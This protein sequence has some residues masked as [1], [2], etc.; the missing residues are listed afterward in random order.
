MRWF[1]EEDNE[2][3]RSLIQAE[4]LQAYRNSDDEIVCWELVQIFAIEPFSPQASGEEVI[5]F[6]ASLGDLTDLL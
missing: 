6:F 2:Q 5:G 1:D 4:P 3:I